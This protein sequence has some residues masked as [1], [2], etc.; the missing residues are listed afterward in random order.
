MACTYTG[1]FI[2][3][4]LF[5][6][7][8]R[9]ETYHDGIF[10]EY[11]ERIRNNE[12]SMLSARENPSANPMV[13]IPQQLCIQ[14]PFEFSKNVSTPVRLQ[15]FEHFIS[16]CCDTI[17]QLLLRS[18]VALRPAKSRKFDRATRDIEY[19]AM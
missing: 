14:D 7:L 4:N 10:K 18:A 13:M 3:K 9:L 15:K 17:E 6:D 19:P 8:N 11:V 5:A 16:L 12:N 1:E 2:D